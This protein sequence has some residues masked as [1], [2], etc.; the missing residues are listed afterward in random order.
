MTTFCYI[1]YYK[2]SERPGVALG[3]NENIFEEKKIEKKVFDFF[4]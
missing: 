4:P 3:K 1:I 2:L